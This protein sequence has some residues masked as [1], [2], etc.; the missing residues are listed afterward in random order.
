MS[1][2]TEDIYAD[3]D[4][5]IEQHRGELISSLNTALSALTQASTAISALTSNQVY[6]VD[7]AEDVAGNDVAAFVADS[8]RLTRAAYAITRDVTDRN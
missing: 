3:W 2:N 5:A 6:D 7:F 1:N 8:M 4:L